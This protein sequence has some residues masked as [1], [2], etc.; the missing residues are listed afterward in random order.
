MDLRVGAAASLDAGEVAGRSKVIPQGISWAA[1]LRRFLKLDSAATV[2]NHFK[3]KHL[4]VDD[5]LAWQPSKKML[6]LSFSL[7]L[8]LFAALFVLKCA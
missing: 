3:L 4:A 1:M 2:S 6:S 5:M 7:F 8:F